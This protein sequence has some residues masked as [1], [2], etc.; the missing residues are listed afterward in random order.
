MAH[1][2]QVI[3]GPDGYRLLLDETGAE[4]DG[5]RLEMEAT[6][7]EAG[8]PPPPHFHPS[9]DESFEVLE[10]A[11][12]AI[13]A[14]EEQRYEAGET[15]A[16]PRETVHQMTG[17]GPARVRWIVTPALR[18]AEFF[19]CLYGEIL[20]GDPAAIGPFL[21]EFAPEISFAGA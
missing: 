11:V 10:G 20:T 8:A 19:E 16:I 15:F 21:V 14:G 6:Y 12:Q 18:T 7:A 9:Q 3:E 2:G 17:A 5:A 4:T 13:V 1:A